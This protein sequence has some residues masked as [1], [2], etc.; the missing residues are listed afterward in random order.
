[1]PNV[2]KPHE[3]PIDPTL[4]DV[5]TN[6]VEDEGPIHEGEIARHLATV[7]GISQAERRI[8]E[9]TTRALSVAAQAG[10][11]KPPPYYLP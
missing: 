10:M 1:V 5:V 3:V 6:I 11:E 7:W 9:V 8:R 2:H 4:R